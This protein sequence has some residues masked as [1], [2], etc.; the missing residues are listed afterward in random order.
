M[1]TPVLRTRVTD[2]NQICQNGRASTVTDVLARPC[3]WQAP[4]SGRDVASKRIVNKFQRPAIPQLDIEGLNP[5]KMSVF[6]H[7]A[8]QCEALVILLQATDCTSAQ[9][10][11][12][13]DY[14]LAGFSL[15]RK[16]GLATFVHEPLKWSFSTNLHLHRRLNGC[17]STL[18]DIE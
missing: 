1:S 17:A 7:L 3:K 5:S 8:A 13:P 9:R 2:R 15:S 14:Q 11:V 12:L 6:Y 18:M 4:F 10:L 16:H